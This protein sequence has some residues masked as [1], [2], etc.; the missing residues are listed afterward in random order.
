MFNRPLVPVILFFITGILVGHAEA[1]YQ[2]IQPFPVFVSIIII[3]V[4]SFFS[5]FSIKK[6][7]FLFIFLLTGILLV[8]NMKIHSDLLPLAQERK[9]VVLEGTILQPGRVSGDMV[10]TELKAERLFFKGNCQ[11]LSEK[12]FLTVYR[13]G[14]DFSPG[15]RIRFPATLHTFKNLVFQLTA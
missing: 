14:I 6:Y 7:L 11:S 9:R 13:H 15:Q 12:V 1:L 2:K 8:L 5:S 10:R 4:F 3:L